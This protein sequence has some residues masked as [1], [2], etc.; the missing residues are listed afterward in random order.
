MKI[1][2]VNVFPQLAISA[3]KEFIRRSIAVLEGMGHE[4]VEVCDSAEIVA[5]A[6]DVVFST[7]QFVGKTTDHFTVGPA[8]NPLDGFRT[9]PKQVEGLRSWDL[10]LPINDVVRRF[11]EDLHHPLPPSAAVSEM[12]FFPSA[13]VLDLPSID[14]A[15]A[16]LAYVG[17]LW[18]GKRHRRLLRT[19]AEKTDFHVYGPA[20]S[21]TFLPRAYRG[22]IP[23]ERDAVSRTLNRHGIVLALHKPSHRDG[24]TPSMRV[25]EACAAHCLVITDRMPALVERFGDTI[26][27][28]DTRAGDDLAAAAILEIVR[29]ARAEPEITRARIAA[30]YD[31]FARTASLDVLMAGVVGAVATAREA[32]VAAQGA[33][34]LAV[35]AVVRTRGHDRSALERTLASLDATGNRSLSVVVVG[36]DPGDVAAL[37]DAR[38]GAGLPVPRFVRVDAG[39]ARSTALR[40]GLERVSDPFVAIMDA[41][42]EVFHDHFREVG[43]VFA[44]EPDIGAVHSG[45][46][47]HHDGDHRPVPH[48]RLVGA[49]GAVHREDRSLGSFADL[50]IA[51]LFDRACAVSINAFVFRSSVLT[52]DVGAD[53]RLDALCDLHLLL[54]ALVGG[55]AMRFTGRMTTVRRLA[56]ADLDPLGRGGAVAEAEYDRLAL[57]WAGRLFPDGRLGRRWFDE[58]RARFHGVVSEPRVRRDGPIKRFLKKIE[59]SLRR[60]FR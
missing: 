16:S 2:F 47:L 15:Q 29:R 7:H 32:R 24:N 42:D 3:E 52:S 18:D 36:T 23:F 27:Y 9:D 11:L 55:T 6:P 17:T 13:P 45:C 38:G 49:D 39:T 58:Q 53:P 1:A 30:A 14:M 35:T 60:R 46:V 50:D 34:D 4:G 48:P 43:A 57:R 37:L 59:R 10:A 33:P 12:E 40:M 28:V 22:S 20:S 5:A 56:G 41:G 21:W 44:R 54:D 8:W 26:E 25:F 51:S 31:I 19:L